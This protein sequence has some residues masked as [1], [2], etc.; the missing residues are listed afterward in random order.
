MRTAGTLNVST[1]IC[2]AGEQKYVRCQ[3]PDVNMYNSLSWFWAAVAWA[4]VAH[5][6]G[7]TRKADLTF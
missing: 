6:P 1:M 4:A 5:V 3:N 7:H 2:T